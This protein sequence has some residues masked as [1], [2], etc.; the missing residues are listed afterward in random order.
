M[1]SPYARPSS[2]TDNQQR[3]LRRL[4]NRCDFIRSACKPLEDNRARK[5]DNDHKPIV[6][7]ISTR[8]VCGRLERR[9]EANDSSI[10]LTENGGSKQR[11]LLESHLIRPD[12]R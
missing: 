4:L 7:A 12:K 8:S 5:P 1:I 2:I 3:Q 10:Q 6:I 9:V 11:Y